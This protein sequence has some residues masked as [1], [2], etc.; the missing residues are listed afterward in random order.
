VKGDV[1]PYMETDGPKVWVPRTV[2]YQRAR[3]VAI[4]AVQDYDQTVRYRG[5]TD[6]TLVGFARDCLCDEVCERRWRD[7]DDTGEWTLDATC[8][9]PA[10]E[11]EIVEKRGPR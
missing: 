5:K 7:D 10:W 11:Y 3:A 4:E 2:P 8:E 9:V 1:G 6:A